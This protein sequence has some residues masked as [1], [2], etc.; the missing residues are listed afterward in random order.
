[1]KTETRQPASS[2]VFI[3]SHKCKWSKS[4]FKINLC[5]STKSAAPKGLAIGV[6]VIDS[7]VQTD[8]QNLGL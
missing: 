1:M 6:L 2:L 7:V 3:K 4:P 8:M 5:T